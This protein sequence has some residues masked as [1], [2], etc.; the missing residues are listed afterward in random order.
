M[1]PSL[2]SPG[3]RLVI[4]ALP[5]SSDA[6]AIAMLAARPDRKRMLVVVCADAAAAQRL[7]DEIA[8]FAPDSA[9]CGKPS[10]VFPP[11][12]FFFAIP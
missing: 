12:R 8:L 11:R 5:G 4:G 6:Y 10:S 1:I 2:P 3:Q 9:A 7:I